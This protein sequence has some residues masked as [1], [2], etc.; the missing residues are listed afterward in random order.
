MTLLCIHVPCRQ[1]KVFPL[2]SVAPVNFEFQLT[3]VQLHSAFTVDPPAGIDT[4]TSDKSYVTGMHV[5][6][7]KRVSE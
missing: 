4:C 2:R 5:L 6:A 1:T 3:F 7:F